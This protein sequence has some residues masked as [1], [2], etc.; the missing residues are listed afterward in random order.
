[1]TSFILVCFDNCTK[2][3]KWFSFSLTAAVSA[4]AKFGAQNDDLLPSVLVL[5]Q[6]YQHHITESDTDLHTFF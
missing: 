6:R 1:M 2:I 4:L 5:M 3:A